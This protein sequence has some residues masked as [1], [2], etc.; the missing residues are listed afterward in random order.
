MKMPVDK[1]G[2]PFSFKEADI[3]WKEKEKIRAEINTYYSK[4]RGQEFAVHLSFGL[5]DNSYAY[6][7]ENRGFD[8]INIYK[9]RSI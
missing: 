2:F 1:N 5:D 6:F 9:R 4:Y 8:D 3:P 7:F